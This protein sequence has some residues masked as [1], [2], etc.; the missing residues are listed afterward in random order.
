M[1]FPLIYILH[2]QQRPHRPCAV[3][4]ASLSEFLAASFFSIIFNISPHFADPFSIFQRYCIITRFPCAFYSTFL[5]DVVC[6]YPLT[7]FGQLHCI[8]FVLFPNLCSSE[9]AVS[10]AQVRQTIKTP[11]NKDTFYT[12]LYISEVN[13]EHLTVTALLHLNFSFLYIVPSI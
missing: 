13:D 5:K 4:S 3:Q 12:L 6:S 8:S 9:R 10:S 7:S 2:Y 1:S 11:V